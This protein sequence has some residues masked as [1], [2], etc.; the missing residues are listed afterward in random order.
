MH[1]FCAIVVPNVREL[2]AN[3]DQGRQSEG[4]GGERYSI[5]NGIIIN[6][7][8][9]TTLLIG[10]SLAQYNHIAI[11]IPRNQPRTPASI[12]PRGG[13]GGRSA[14]SNLSLI[15]KTTMHA[16][17]FIYPTRGCLTTFP[18]SST[19]IRTRSSL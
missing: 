10:C 16:N 4:G 18:F 6:S 11:P 12:C 8:F 9:Y 19:I 15:Y 3:R 13:G 2:E 17:I 7:S 1:I 5:K 14:L